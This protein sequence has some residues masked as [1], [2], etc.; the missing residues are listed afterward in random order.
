MYKRFL[1]ALYKAYVC[2]GS[3]S[4]DATT[5]LGFTEKVTDLFLSWL[6]FIDV[7]VFRIVS[8]AEVRDSLVSYSK[9]PSYLLCAVSYK[10][11]TTV[12]N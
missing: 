3:G 2:F 10:N 4:Y 11:T 9:P 6:Q 8:I 1:L 12:I 5:R 7:D